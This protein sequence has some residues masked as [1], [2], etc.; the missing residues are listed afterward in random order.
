MSNFV[1]G[2]VRIGL[3]Y[4]YAGAASAVP[5]TVTEAADAPGAAEKSNFVESS[6]KRTRLCP[7][8][9]AVTVPGFTMLLATAAAGSFGTM[10]ASAVTLTAAAAGGP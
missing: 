3:S 9:A 7:V 8:A 10:P 2:A 4:S 1:E 5:L 6:L